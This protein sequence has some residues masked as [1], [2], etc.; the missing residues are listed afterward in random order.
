MTTI[1]FN[2]NNNN[3]N[4][5][6]NNNNNNNPNYYIIENGQNTENSPGDLGRSAVTQTLVKN[7]RL[8]LM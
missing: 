7:H 5:N 6:E 4:N 8:T 2:N 3:N 1:E